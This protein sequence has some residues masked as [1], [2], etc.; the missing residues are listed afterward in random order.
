VQNKAPRREIRVFYKTENML[1]PQLKYQKEN[2][3]VACMVSF[4]PTLEN[5]Q[6]QDAEMTNEQP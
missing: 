3:E 1:Q 5:K 2:G 6:P 4:V